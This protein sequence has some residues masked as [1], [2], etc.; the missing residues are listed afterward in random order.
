MSVMPEKEMESVVRLIANEIHQRVIWISRWTGY[1]NPVFSIEFSPIGE[2][3]KLEYVAEQEPWKGA[4][5]KYFSDV[6]K[7]IIPALNFYNRLGLKKITT[8]RTRGVLGMIDVEIDIDG[9]KY[10]MPISLNDTVVPF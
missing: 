8:R 4:Q 2:D 7:H 5:K 3:P 1:F 9:N 6:E 10:I